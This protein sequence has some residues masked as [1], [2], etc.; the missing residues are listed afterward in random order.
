MEQT[1]FYTFSTIPQVLA[2]VVALVG[3]FVL[4]RLPQLDDELTSIGQQILRHNS[5]NQLAREMRA[6]GFDSGPIEGM[7]E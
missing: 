1:L 6:A 5:T 7:T 3:V 4:Y 2:A